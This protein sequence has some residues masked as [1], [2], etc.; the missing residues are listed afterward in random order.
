MTYNKTRTNLSQGY[1][2]KEPGTVNKCR[3]DDE[4]DFQLHFQHVYKQLVSL[5]KYKYYPL[6]FLKRIR[7][8]TKLKKTMNDKAF[9]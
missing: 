5:M 6:L 8:I 1:C 9:V 3:F 2:Y 7:F 4:N